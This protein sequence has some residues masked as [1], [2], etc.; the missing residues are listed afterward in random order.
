MIHQAPSRIQSLPC[1]IQHQ[2]VMIPHLLGARY[3]PRP[4]I[5]LALHLQSGGLS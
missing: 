2:S 4:F 3:G 5:V 1:E